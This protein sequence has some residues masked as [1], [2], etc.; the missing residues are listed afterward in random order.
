M[1]TGNLFLAAALVTVP[2]HASDPFA[3][4][5][6]SVVAAFL[7]N[8]FQ[9]GQP[10]F[11]TEAPADFTKLALPEGFALVGSKV[12][13]MG[14]TLVYR[15]EDEK[16]PAYHAAIDAMEDDGWWELGSP[17]QVGGGFQTQRLPSYSLLCREGQKL[18]LVITAWKRDGMTFV[19]YAEGTGG[20]RCDRPGIPAWVSRPGD[21]RMP[22]L[23][24]PDGIDGGYPGASGGDSQQTSY[25]DVAA[26]EDRQAMAAHLETQLRE[27]GWQHRGS[28]ATD[29]AI[30]S[31]WTRKLNAEGLAVANLLLMR[32]SDSTE[33]LSINVAWNDG[34][35][36]DQLWGSPAG[37]TGQRLMRVPM[38]E[39]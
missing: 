26:L 15:S 18:S 33:R 28:W 3:C 39:E 35:S 8:T 14:R 1:K 11:S 9:G 19:S 27:Q 22:D 38:P 29:D 32:R 37:A 30:G 4:V 24:L 2:C 31:A 6:D 21:R 5:D 36:G 20:M 12:E 23:Y 25:I 16:G 7:G 13:G 17:G 34:T 10:T